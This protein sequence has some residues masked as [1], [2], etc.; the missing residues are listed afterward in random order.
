MRC[1]ECKWSKSKTTLG[2][3]NIIE[4][5]L[6]CHYQAPQATLIPTPRGMISVTARPEVQPDEFC[7]EHQPKESQIA[8]I[9]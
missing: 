9:Q 4:T 2:E 5:K 1:D 6:Y 7:K 8:S 3:G